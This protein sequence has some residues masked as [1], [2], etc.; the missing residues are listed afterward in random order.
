MLFYLKDNVFDLKK[1]GE[2]EKTTDICLWANAPR[3]KK[4][5]QIR[6]LI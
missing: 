2:E 3:H 1:I 5:P 4:N 6:K